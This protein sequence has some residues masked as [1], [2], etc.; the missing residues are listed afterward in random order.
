MSAFDAFVA[1]ATE[2]GSRTVEVISRQS[3]ATRRDV[4]AVAPFGG[5]TISGPQAIDRSGMIG[6][7][8]GRINVFPSA[9]VGIT[10]T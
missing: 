7:P 4:G 1:A 9:A 8:I 3:S 2:H 5:R 6:S 10:S